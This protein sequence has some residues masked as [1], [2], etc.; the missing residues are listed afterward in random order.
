MASQDNDRSLVPRDGSVGL[1]Q[2]GT[3]DWTRMGSSIVRFSVDFLIRI[4][5]GGVEGITIHAAQAVLSKLKLSVEGEQRVHDAIGKLSAYSS[6]NTALWFGFGIKHIIRQL[7]ETEEGLNCIA[8]CAALQEMYSTTDTAK[9]L[10]E[11]VH[12]SGAPARVMPS[13][14]QWISFAE[15]CSGA[16]ASTDFGTHLHTISRSFL[17]Q[18]SS[19]L[20]RRSD[21]QH[22]A[23]AINALIAVSNGTLEN[24]RLLGGADCGWISAF[25]VWMLSL[26]VLIQDAAGNEL[27]RFPEQSL[28]DPKLTV[29]FGDHSSAS[30]KLVKKS[31]VV[32]SGDALIHEFDVEKHVVQGGDILS[33]GRVPWQS[34]LKDTFGNAARLLIDGPMTTSCGTVLGC[35]ARIFTVVLSDDPD[36]PN[37]HFVYRAVWKYIAS[38]SHGRGF[39]NTVQQCLPEMTA[40]SKLMNAMEQAIGLT[41]INAVAAY[42]QHMMRIAEICT[43]KRCKPNSGWSS[44]DSETE[45]ITSTQ[46]SRTFCMVT[47]VECMIELVQILSQINPS[48]NILP[49]RSGVENIYWHSWI[50]HWDQR[51]GDMKSYVYDC[52]LDQEDRSTLFAAK[53]L[54]EGRENE[55]ERVEASALATGGICFYYDI[56]IG[57]SADQNQCRLI[58]LVPG[59]IEWQDHLFN[60]IYDTPHT[61]HGLRQL[62]LRGTEYRATLGT[63]CLATSIPHL[64]ESTSPDLKAEL[65]IE[66]DEERESYTKTL[67][68]SYRFTTS[69]GWFCFTPFAMTNMISNAVTAKDCRGR[70]CGPLP[71]FNICPTFGEGF[72]NANDIPRHL[73]LVLIAHQN[74]PAQLVAVCQERTWGV[75]SRS[76]LQAT[77]SSGR[78][79]YLQNK[80]CLRCLVMR[81]IKEREPDDEDHLPSCYVCIAAFS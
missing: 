42:E 9:I 70:T 61:P 56:L 25:A 5:N 23:N 16:L 48:H 29:I 69:Q 41:Y 43:C 34:V 3:I 54:F 36:F 64:Q 50:R 75:T 60:R 20:H 53:A 78:R 81:A 68:A 28:L 63:A 45:G 30:V 24:I 19:T 58:H 21:I 11:L 6:I 40:S 18:D 27:Y 13:L 80:E 49:A 12:L 7:A 67:L 4:S 47:L 1:Q 79:N 14:R 38:S 76:C 73:A 71:S 22:I 15:V 77:D 51:K 35:A 8:I 74:V 65:L 2:Q 32:P 46:T 55:R 31:F 10:R 39:V 33:C 59:R 72:I 66:D 44:D 17:L 57:L 37:D 52:L 26:P 62:K